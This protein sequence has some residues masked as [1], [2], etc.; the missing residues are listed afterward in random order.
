MELATNQRQII[1]VVPKGL[2]PGNYDLIVTNDVGVGSDMKPDL[3][4]ID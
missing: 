2:P 3:F 4:N 1:F